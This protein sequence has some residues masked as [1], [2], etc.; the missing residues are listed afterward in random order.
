VGAHAPEIAERTEVG[1]LAR[2][3]EEFKALMTAA[4]S[5]EGAPEGFE[6]APE[7]DLEREMG[8]LESELQKCY[9]IAGDLATCEFKETELPEPPEFKDDKD[10]ALKIAHAKQWTGHYLNMKKKTCNEKQLPVVSFGCCHCTGGTTK[11]HVDHGNVDGCEEKCDI[12]KKAFQLFADGRIKIHNCRTYEWVDIIPG[13]ENDFG[14]LPGMEKLGVSK[15]YRY[16]AGCMEADKCWLG[17]DIKPVSKKG[18]LAD[19]VA[20]ALGDAKETKMKKKLL[21]A[22]TYTSTA[23]RWPRGLVIGCSH[24]TSKTRKSWAS[25][26]GASVF[27]RDAENNLLKDEDGNVLIMTNDPEGTHFN[28]EDFGKWF[29]PMNVA[30]CKVLMEDIYKKLG[31]EEGTIA[32]GLIVQNTPRS[33]EFGIDLAAPA[34]GE[35]DSPEIYGEGAPAKLDTADGLTLNGLSYMMAS[36]HCARSEAECDKWSDELCKG[37]CSKQCDANEEDC[38]TCCAWNE[39]LCGSKDGPKECKP[40]VE[41]VGKLVQVT[42]PDGVTDGQQLF[43]QAN[44]EQVRLIVP[45]GKKS[46]DQFWLQ[47]PATSTCDDDGTISCEEKSCTAENYASKYLSPVTV[48]SF[49][50]LDVWSGNVPP[51][52]SSLCAAKRACFKHEVLGPN[53]RNSWAAL[54]KL[55]MKI[56]SGTELTFLCNPT[57]DALF[58]KEEPLQQMLKFNHPHVQRVVEGWKEMCSALDKERSITDEL[59]AMK[60]FEEK[61]KPSLWLSLPDPALLFDVFQ[62]VVDYGVS[63]DDLAE[64]DKDIVGSDA[65][66]AVEEEVLGGGASAEEGQTQSEGFQT[67]VN[68]LS[69]NNEVVGK[70]TKIFGLAANCGV[71][72]G[73]AIVSGGVSETGGAV[74]ACGKLVAGAIKMLVD[75]IVKQTELKMT[76]KPCDDFKSEVYHLG[77]YTGRGIASLAEAQGNAY[78]LVEKYGMKPNSLGQGKVYFAQMQCMH[79]ATLRYLKSP[80]PH[81]G[82]GTE[83]AQINCGGGS[84]LDADEAKATAALRDMLLK[85]TQ[86]ETSSGIDVAIRAKRKAELN[87]E[88]AVTLSHLVDGVRA[89]LSLQQSLVG[90][91]SDSAKQAAKATLARLDAH[92]VSM[93]WSWRSVTC[94]AGHR[95]GLQCP[96]ESSVYYDEAKADEMCKG[97]ED[98]R[99]TENPPRAGSS[100]CTQEDDFKDASST[101]C[102]KGESCASGSEKK[103]TTYKGGWE[104]HYRSCP[105]YEEAALQKLPFPFYTLVPDMPC[106]GEAC[107]D[108]DFF[109]WDSDP[110]QP[111]PCCRPAV[112]HETCDKGKDRLKGEELC[113]GDELTL[114]ENP[115][116]TPCKAAWCNKDDDF[117]GAGSTCCKATSESL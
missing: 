64:Y 74:A 55:T 45:E 35:T 103:W 117:K 105:K 71:A 36:D 77:Q 40:C 52:T 20:L 102:R 113:A 115:E 58:P 109:D 42:V 29:G 73:G 17:V 19:W 104:E 78:E 7:R 15:G 89:A 107:T 50:E 66:K 47:M 62:S 90:E 56:S 16:Y 37:E 69:G 6:M 23:D 43:V 114:K 49:K 93:T 22:E 13:G 81:L 63:V 68:E 32:S 5:G 75:A 21:E 14:Y 33:K 53:T 65:A 26:V 70:V 25:V 84:K 30:A 110:K 83:A 4:E 9:K 1:S 82:V 59:Y 39:K 57:K 11:N 2:D 41:E 80:G 96:G 31:G 111:G 54:T 98:T 48:A 101:C 18:I 95:V 28:G 100:K 72:I 79:R 112:D 92:A 108:V 61:M 44:G 87:S 67:A 86:W 27:K 91:P 94:A 34:E 97:S 60:K 24:G 46:G 99:D 12:E 88:N 85:W 116:G 8:A 10:M 3:L 51:Y 38:D 76:R 106:K